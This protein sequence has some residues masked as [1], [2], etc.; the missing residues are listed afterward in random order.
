M[1][2]RILLVSATIVCLSS[3]LQGCVHLDPEA[4][5]TLTELGKDEKAEKETLAEEEQRFQNVR[6]AIHKERLTEG[7]SGQEAAD[8]FGAPAAALSEGK[9]QKWVYKGKGGWFKAS[10]IYLYFDESN[11]LKH[12]KCLRTDC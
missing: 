4:K 8:Q 3:E 12:W 1:E 6:K 5:H 10:K 11:H 2:S 9:D 7:L